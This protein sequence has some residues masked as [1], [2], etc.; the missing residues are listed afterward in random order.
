MNLIHI[1]DCYYWI[2]IQSAIDNERCLWLW[3]SNANVNYG[4]IYSALYVTYTWDTFY[5]G[6]AISHCDSMKHG[7]TSYHNKICRIPQGRIHVWS[8]SAPPPPP[9]WQ[10]NHA[11]SAYFRLF[12]G[13][14]SGYISHPA[15]LLDLPP[16][17]LHILDPPLRCLTYGAAQPLALYR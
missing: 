10:I 5:T 13:L 3:V 1:I 16:P 8:E 9:F 4:K 2:W 15:P 6:Y 7:H 17:F 12:L 14:F 11:N